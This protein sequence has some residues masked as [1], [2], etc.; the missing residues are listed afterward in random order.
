MKNEPMLKT[1]LT[2][3]FATKR[4]KRKTSGVWSPKHFF[5]TMLLGL[6]LQSSASSPTPSGFA[7]SL[8]LMMAGIALARVYVNTTLKAHVAQKGKKND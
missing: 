5:P 2:K 8:I 4:E 1:R 3:D 6:L 7:V